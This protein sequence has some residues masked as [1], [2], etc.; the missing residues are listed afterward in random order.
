MSHRLVAQ[1][2]KA[3]CSGK[4]AGY[5]MVGTSIVMCWLCIQHWTQQ[6]LLSALHYLQ[7]EQVWHK[8]PGLC[9]QPLICILQ[10]HIHL[11]HLSLHCD[12][13]EITVFPC[14]NFSFCNGYVLHIHQKVNFSE[15]C[16]CN[17]WNTKTWI[18]YFL[19]TGKLIRACSEIKLSNP[20]SVFMSLSF[21]FVWIVK[22]T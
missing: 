12:W 6:D 11:L 16:I 15:Y 14:H 8:S 17:N 13:T 7:D 18:F 4:V 1:L 22:C 2:E 5:C 9:P 19:Y 21:L 10:T 20:S 3:Q